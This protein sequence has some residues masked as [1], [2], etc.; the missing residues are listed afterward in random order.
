MQR[1]SRDYSPGGQERSHRGS[2]FHT[3]IPNSPQNY[4][5]SSKNS[6]VSAN[7]SMR[8]VQ[9]QA[10]LSNKLDRLREEIKREMDAIR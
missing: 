3:N 9:R 2:K 5:D 4:R 6:R 8:G 7:R 1:L 10:G